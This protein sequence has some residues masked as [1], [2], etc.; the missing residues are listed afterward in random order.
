MDITKAKLDLLDMTLP[1]AIALDFGGARHTA[2][3]EH[4]AAR[5][6]PVTIVDANIPRV[7][8]APSITVV[9]GN[10]ADA[11]FLRDNVQPAKLAIMYDILLH[12]YG[13]LDT[14]RLMLAYASDA[15]CIGQPCL[16]PARSSP[17]ESMVFLPAVPLH[18]QADL[19]PRFQ[20]GIYG[21]KGFFQPDAYT[22]AQWL[23]GIPPALLRCW[24]EREGW[25]IAAERTVPYSPGWVWWGCYA[26]R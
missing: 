5:G 12:Q 9:R 17:E 21:D 26:T 8:I 22:C 1:A 11:G 20:D 10:F 15:V 2:Y 23:W 19:V 14:L 7:P 25:T 6:T 24:V 4:C 18:R 13:P 3:A 16:S